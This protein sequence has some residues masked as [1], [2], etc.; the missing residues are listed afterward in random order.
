[1]NLQ[2]NLATKVYVD[3]RKVNLVLLVLISLACGWCAFSLYTVASNYGEIRQLSEYKAKS[4]AKT[5]GGKISDVEFNRLMAEVKLANVILD[6]RRYDWLT[7]LDNLE[8]VVP[9]GVSLN[10]I[11]PGE[12]S[13][14]IKVV[15]TARNFAA[16]RKFVE[17]L[18]GSSKFADVFLAELKYVKEGPTNKGISFTVTCKALF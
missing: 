2:L 16:V 17:N 12:K 1:V 9:D 10:S 11:A 14:L 7:Q 13:E 8:V 5:S 4:L 6:K 15:A 18:E 3:F